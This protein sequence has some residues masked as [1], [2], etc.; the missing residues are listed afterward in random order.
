MP[1][2]STEIQM[3]LTGV[4]NASALLD[5]A[6]QKLA[7]MQ[8]ASAKAS[9]KLRDA[10]LGAGKALLFTGPLAALRTLRRGLLATAGAAAAL[11]YATDRSAARLGELSDAAAQAGASADE[12][13][14]LSQ[15][16]GQAG[17]RGASVD[18]IS[19][20]LARM[21]KT[22]GRTGIA[23][24]RET[25]AEIAAL[26][27]EAARI[28]ALSDTFGKALGPQFAAL[29]R[30]GPDALREGLDGVV[31]AMP[32][33]SDSVVDAGDAIA[34]GM[35][36]IRTSIR[37]G[38]DQMLV[39]VAQ[40][41][42]THFGADSFRELGA[43][44]GAY[45]EYYAQ[46]AI[47]NLV[48]LW[49]HLKFYAANLPRLFGA[50]F[51]DIGDAIHANL[52]RGLDALGRFLPAL[53]IYTRAFGAAGNLSA[54]DWEG[55]W[56]T[57]TSGPA[58]QEAG[59]NL[60]AVLA[61]FAGREFVTHADDLDAKLAERLAAVSGLDEAM[62]KLAT[63]ATAA[64]E[65]AF[66]EAADSAADLGKAGAAAAKKTAEAWRGAG[67]VMAGSYEALKLA[68]RRTAAAAASA[69]SPAS[70][71][72]SSSSP[73]AAESTLLQVQRDGWAFLRSSLG[74]LGVV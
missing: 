22:T 74:S 60:G 35:G 43:R 46:L 39:S 55:A 68:I 57:L 18:T 9:H 5:A 53:R 72:S 11:A 30:Q 27:D 38:W 33:L 36:S 26:P 37:N 47:R 40:S 17:V 2:S 10:A 24:L 21:A 54:G 13:Q 70:S 66:D 67:A 69:L 12:I 4:D 31:A 59:S 51:R 56:E 73:A 29:V 41:V 6:T 14:R 23:G 42:A 71:G 44:V 28:V 62:G 63:G 52:T 1:A 3:R 61:E 8:G 15:A 34:D 58:A 25:L 19:N 49:D 20:A 16:L 65:D 45:V 32:R 64:A 50:A 7:K 48:P